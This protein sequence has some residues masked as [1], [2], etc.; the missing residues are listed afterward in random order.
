MCAVFSS[1]VCTISRGA[2]LGVMMDLQVVCARPSTIQPTKIN[3]YWK[4]FW[5]PSETM[6]N[7]SSIL[8]EKP[9]LNSPLS[10]NLGLL[11]K[12]WGPSEYGSVCV[13]RLFIESLASPHVL[14]PHS[15]GVFIRPITLTNICYTFLSLFYLSFT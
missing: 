4:I 9:C 2:T 14:I 5:R 12:D 10:W 1:I 7:P 3:L 13:K 6:V 15:V 11:G 8:S